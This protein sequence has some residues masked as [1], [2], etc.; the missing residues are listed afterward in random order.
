MTEAATVFWLVAKYEPDLAR[1]EPRNVGVVLSHSGCI[2]ARFLGES[3]EERSLAQSTVR[4]E[5]MLQAWIGSW[6]NDIERGE[7]PGKRRAGDNYY[8][9]RGGHVLAG[10][11]Q[12]AE[13]LLERLFRE[14]VLPT[15]D[16]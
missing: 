15:E 13:A 10:D 7:L 14:L 4:S 16:R 1:A 6:R 3:S 9:V 11:P 5:D 2:S 12:P 8:C